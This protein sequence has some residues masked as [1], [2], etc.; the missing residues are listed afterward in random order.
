MIVNL[1]IKYKS[2]K[3]GSDQKYSSKYPIHATSAQG[4]TENTPYISWGRTQ[5]IFYD[6]HFTTV[7][8]HKNVQ[9]YY[10]EKC[11]YNVNANC[12]LLYTLKVWNCLNFI[13]K[14]R[15]I[16]FCLI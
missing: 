15:L 10:N 13:G 7:T 4:T 6:K 14:R 3:F 5:K 12:N 2:K 9:S 1:K 16:F 8:T 11:T